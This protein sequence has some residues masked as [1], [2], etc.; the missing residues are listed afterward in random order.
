MSARRTTL[1]AALTAALLVPVGAA[2]ARQQEQQ[3]KPKAAAPKAFNHP[4]VLVSRAQLD[5]VKAKVKAGAQ[6]WKKAHDT[7]RASRFASLGY[8]AK[9]RATVECG[10]RSNPNHGC[11]DEREDG[12]AA[13]T[14]ALQWYITGDARH[15]RKAIQIMDAW[16]PVIKRHTNHNAPLQTGWSGANWSRAAEIIAHTG[17]GWSAA[18]INRFKTMLRTV[19]LPTVIKGSP[20]TN[21]NW[22]LIMTDAAIGIAVFLDD[23]ASFDK[24]VTTWRGRVPAYFYVKSD[25]AQPRTP[26][27]SNKNTKAKL[28][29]YWH[30]QARLE[31][32]L[33]QETCRDFGHTGWGLDAAAHA[34]ET[35]R[36][37][38][39]DLYTGA[40]ERLVSAMEFH[41]SYELGRPAP[42]WLCKGSLKK[43]L[44]P[45]P[46]LLYNHFHNRAKVTMPETKRLIETRSRPTGAGHF[47]AW[48]TL[49][50]AQ[51][52]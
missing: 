35:A 23:R 16:S 46:E 32:G 18:G 19:Y 40:R 42:S 25:G 36:H 44:G 17:G 3:A 12:I 11:S 29:T 31:T 21:G 45:T 39:V 51:N 14:H 1:I 8:T 33:A 30:N 48:E 49:T 43:G 38:G 6:P 37:Q 20:N 9:P 41:A 22:E 26:P 4:G 15:A 7:M 5:V 2:V 13:Y 27:G 52:P 24:A 10:S 47:I 28:L 50:H 34:A